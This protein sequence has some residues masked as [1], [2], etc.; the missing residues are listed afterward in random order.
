MFILISWESPNYSTFCFSLLEFCLRKSYVGFIDF[1][2]YKG[3]SRTSSQLPAQCRKPLLIVLV[4]GSQLL[5]EHFLCKRI[6]SLFLF[7]GAL[8]IHILILT[9][10]YY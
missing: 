9:E 1:L 8:N 6:H 2:S 10:S 5:P 4:T 3:S 7:Q